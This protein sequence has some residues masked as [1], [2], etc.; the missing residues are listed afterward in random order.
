MTDDDEDVTEIP[1][2]LELAREL[3]AAQ[4]ALAR[5]E[6][7]AAAYRLSQL[8]VEPKCPSCG[9]GVLRQKCFHDM[10]DCPRH[11]VAEQYGG[12]NAIHE[13]LEN[14]SPNVIFVR[15]D[16]EG[17]TFFAKI[18]YHKSVSFQYGKTTEK[19]SVW[20][21]LYK[22]GRYPN[23]ALKNF[24][25]NQM[26]IKGEDNH[27]WEASKVLG[28]KSYEWIETD[29]LTY[30]DKFMHHLGFAYGT[31]TAISRPATFELSNLT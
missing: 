2:P 30:A 20:C 7:R 14:L 22:N 18:A 12:S 4:S 29:L 8:T 23:K 6:R 27:V 31:I 15:V 11:D 24:V 19:E 5:V 16:A 13:R 10:D 28:G 3:E 1:L 9:S 26:K 17:I 25:E 21:E